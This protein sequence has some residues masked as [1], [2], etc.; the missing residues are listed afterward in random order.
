MAERGAKIKLRSW[1]RATVD[2]S[3]D[4]C[5]RRVPPSGLSASYLA[6]TRTTRRHPSWT[7]GS[8]FGARWAIDIRRARSPSKRFL[9]T[10]ET[11]ERDS[12]GAI[13]VDWFATLPRLSWR[14]GSIR[15]RMRAECA[16][17]VAQQPDSF[18]PMSF[19]FEFRFLIA[20]KLLFQ[21][22][23][24]LGI[25][26][27]SFYYNVANFYR[28]TLNVFLCYFLSLKIEIYK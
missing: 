6:A 16:D 19:S 11:G 28:Y 7:E 3:S 27:F 14:F 4:A 24:N 5:D 13:M 20:R 21:L 26:Y 18:G 22:A 8:A 23:T 10:Q 12:T 9:Q 1:G 25:F 15:W 2:L 17:G